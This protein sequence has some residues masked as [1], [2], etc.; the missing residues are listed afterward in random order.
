MAIAWLGCL[1]CPRNIDGTVGIEFDN[2]DGS[3]NDYQTGQGTVLEIQ[4]P[5]SFCPSGSQLIVRWVSFDDVG[6]TF[7]SLQ[8]S[9]G[10]ESLTYRLILG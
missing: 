3:I 10:C 8:F 1:L 2:S 5:P 7:C 9:S 4:Q 6:G